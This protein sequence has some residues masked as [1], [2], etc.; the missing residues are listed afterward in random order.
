MPFALRNR[1]RNEPA[2][3]TVVIPAYNAAATLGAAIKSVLV[4]TLPPAEVIVVDDGSSDESATIAAAHGVDVLRQSNRGEA[5][6]RNT[7]I[8]ASGEEWIAFLD[9][10]DLWEPEKLQQQWSAHEVCQDAGLVSSDFS[11]FR[12]ERDVLVP[13]F[14]H[15][16]NSGYLALERTSVAPGISYFPRIDARVLSA[17]FFLFPSAVLIRR[18][19]LLSAGLFDESLGLGTDLE[20]F[21]RALTRTSMV[22]VE[23][24]LM[25]YRIH[26][27]NLSKD[28]LGATL[29]FIQVAA[30]VSAHPERYPPGASRIYSI[31][32]PAKLADAGRLLLQAR[33]RRHARKM[34]QLSLMKRPSVRAVALWVATWLS[35][36]IFNWFIIWKRRATYVSLWPSPRRK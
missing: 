28:T 19:L 14:L 6:A 26:E 17:G 13:S 36:D 9:A 8:L 4:Q 5:G 3:I 18:D 31:A 10:D 12:G 1:T 23:R 35:S 11:Q 21:I 22:V 30:R 33:D 24:P 27:R 25:R 16:Q 20:C 7:G 29:G 32:V 2:P 34:L 15:S